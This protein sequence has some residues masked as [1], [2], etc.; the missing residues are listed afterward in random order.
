MDMSKYKPLFLSET[1]EHLDA[2]EADLVALE[3]SPQDSPRVH[4]IF[5]HLHSVKSMAAS[6]GY[7]PLSTLAHRLEDLVAPHREHG[8]QD[9]KSVV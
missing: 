1:G 9:R 4:E 3:N 7:Q 5:R 8:L 6:M 2:L